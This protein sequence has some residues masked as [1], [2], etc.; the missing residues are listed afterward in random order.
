[1]IYVDKHFPS[2]FCTAHDIRSMQYRKNIYNSWK[3]FYEDSVNKNPADHFISYW[4]FF[5]KYAHTGK[6]YI[7]LSNEDL[8][9]ELM[10]AVELS[11]GFCLWLSPPIIYEDTFKLH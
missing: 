7:S 11:E 2:E 4:Y 10:E 6:L 1:M 5:K 8:S 9:L 3:L